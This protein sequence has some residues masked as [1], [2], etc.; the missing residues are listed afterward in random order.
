MD[1]PRKRSAGQ[2]GREQTQGLDFAAGAAGSAAHGSSLAG[3]VEQAL[4]G[5][6][7]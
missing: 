5:L 7:A 2:A 1:R 4:D 3:C 6:A